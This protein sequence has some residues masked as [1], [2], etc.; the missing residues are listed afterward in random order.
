MTFKLNTRN[1]DDVVIIDMNGRLTC[2]EPRELLRAAIRR[3][4]DEGNGRF[5]LNLSDVSY[6]DTSGLNE[7]LSTQTMLVEH[8]G[9][10]NLFG[11]TRKVQDLLVMTKLIV[12]FDCFEK[13]SEAIAALQR[14]EVKAT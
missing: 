10:V 14:G 7:L 11:V 12:V 2:D 1:V 8:D 3:L 4:F 9:E 13:E 5:V 6:V